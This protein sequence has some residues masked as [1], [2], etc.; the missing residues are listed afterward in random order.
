MIVF[1]VV[2]MRVIAISIFK[3]KYWTPNFR[4]SYGLSYYSLG[5]PV[6][7]ILGYRKLNYNTEC[8][9]MDK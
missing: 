4:G 6:I 5:N 9:G 7:L 8:S 3:L 1:F 2:Y